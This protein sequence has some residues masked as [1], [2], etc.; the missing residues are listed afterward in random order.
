MPTIIKQTVD[1]QGN[2]LRE[3][4]LEE[5]S[6]YMSLAAAGRYHGVSP[7]TIQDW[8]RKGLLKK[9]VI[10]GTHIVRVRRDEIEALFEPVPFEPESTQAP[11]PE[12]Q[13]V[14]D[15]EPEGPL[16]PYPHGRS[17]TAKGRKTTYEPSRARQV[18]APEPRWPEDESNI[19]S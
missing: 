4:V 12:P 18:T 2:V 5:R 15:Q 19:G 6:P 7:W 13:P 17:V 3:E 14:Q 16:G 8:T 1:E 11:D 10:K 9:Y